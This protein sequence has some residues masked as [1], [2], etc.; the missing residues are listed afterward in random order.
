MGNQPSPQSI[1]MENSFWP[2][3]IA[4]YDRTMYLVGHHAMLILFTLCMSMIGQ[5][6][7]VLIDPN[8]DGGFESGAVSSVGLRW[9]GFGLKRPIEI[10]AP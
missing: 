9:S 4:Y 2:I 5:A 10:R 6:Q 8:T 3:F 7:T 1:Q